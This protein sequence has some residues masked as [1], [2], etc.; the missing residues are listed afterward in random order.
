MEKK[1]SEVWLEELNNSG[2]DYI[3]VYDPDGWDRQ[4]YQFSFYEEEITETEFTNRLG[5]STVLI[6]KKPKKTD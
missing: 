3:I 2:D 6:K 1:T 5:S 4:N